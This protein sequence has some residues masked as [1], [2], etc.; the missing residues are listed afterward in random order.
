MRIDR[1]GRPSGRFVAPEGV[2]FTSR[3][4]PP[5][6]ANGPYYRY[7]VVRPIEVCG[8]ISTPWFG[9][10]GFG[11]QYELNRPVQTYIDSGHLRPLD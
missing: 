3:S 7:E 1:Y 6:A 11:V 5:E 2:P 8:G 9:Q 4:L 10:R